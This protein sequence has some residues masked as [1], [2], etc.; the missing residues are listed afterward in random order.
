M[1]ASRVRAPGP[2]FTPTATHRSATPHRSA[3]TRGS[4]ALRSLGAPQVDS[5]A[6]TA[7]G[8]PRS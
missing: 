7:C 8:H 6:G 4:T 3:A 1:P 2:P 5:F